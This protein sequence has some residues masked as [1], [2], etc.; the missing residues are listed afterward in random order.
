MQIDFMDYTVALGLGAALAVG[1]LLQVGR[2]VIKARYDR[3]VRNRA[4]LGQEVGEYSVCRHGVDNAG[5]WVRVRTSVRAK[6]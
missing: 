6:N 2:K 4:A 3:R 1:F 5:N